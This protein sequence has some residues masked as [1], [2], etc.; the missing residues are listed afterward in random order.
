[1]SSIRTDFTDIIEEIKKVK[2]PGVTTQT[3]PLSQGAIWANFSPTVFPNNWAASHW[4]SFCNFPQPVPLQ[5]NDAYPIMASSTTVVQQDLSLVLSTDP[6][7]AANNITS[8]SAVA[9]IMTWFL[10]IQTE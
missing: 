6:Y 4:L 2:Q 10:K 7:Q 8:Q 5:P 1:M 3:E 9:V